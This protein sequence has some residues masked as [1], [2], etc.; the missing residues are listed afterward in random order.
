LVQIEEDAHRAK[1]TR[2]SHVGLLA[3]RIAHHWGRRPK[4]R[5]LLALLGPG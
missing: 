2:R 3:A 4:R 1:P 5:G